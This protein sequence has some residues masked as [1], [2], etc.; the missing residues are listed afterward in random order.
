MWYM[1]FHIAC[2]PILFVR[3]VFKC[4]CGFSPRSAAFFRIYT[5]ILSLFLSFAK[6]MDDWTWLPKVGCSKLDEIVGPYRIMMH[7]L[8]S[9]FRNH[10]PRTSP[11]P[12]KSC[13]MH[14]DHLDVY[15]MMLHSLPH[16]L[17]PL[18]RSGIFTVRIPVEMQKRSSCCTCR[19]KTKS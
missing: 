1:N 12:T 19:R 4:G 17:P 16:L 8:L 7:S 6:G 5:D 15:R 3:G 9:D 11:R 18:C 10:T 14:A 13:C 2:I